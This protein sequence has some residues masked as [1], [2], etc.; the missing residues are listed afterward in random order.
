VK[1]KKQQNQ[2]DSKEESEKT[3]RR[4]KKPPPSG[5]SSQAGEVGGEHWDTGA[6][7]N[8]FCV[9]SARKGDSPRKRKGSNQEGKRHRTTTSQVTMTKHSEL[10]MTPQED[11]G[12][13]GNLLLLSFKKLRKL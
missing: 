2:N 6:R 5:N 9:E 13:A 3:A 12:A 4:K 10:K 1:A 7:K 11:I 8:P